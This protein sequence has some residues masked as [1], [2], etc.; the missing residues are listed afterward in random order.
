MKRNMPNKK[1]ILQYWSDI[2]FDPPIDTNTCFACG[3]T[4]GTERAHIKA[5]CDG[6]ADEKENLFLLCKRCHISQEAICSDEKNIE[7]FIDSI[8]DGAPFMR[9]RGLEYLTMSEI[10]N[11]KSADI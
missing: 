5:K 3:F 9:V 1:T 6:G 2:I 4:N 10:V 7:N 8:I 11:C